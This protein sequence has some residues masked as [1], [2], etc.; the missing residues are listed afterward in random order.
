MVPLGERR[1]VCGQVSECGLPAVLG[2]AA[3]TLAEAT[4][5]SP[6]RRD[7][8]ESQMPLQQITGGDNVGCLKSELEPSH[9]L[10]RALWLDCEKRM[11]LSSHI[12]QAV[13]CSPEPVKALLRHSEDYELHNS[14]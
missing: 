2:Q 10:G 4:V 7:L 14:F 9:Q 3:F 1:R 6:E 5:L 12:P 8:A 13:T 11:A